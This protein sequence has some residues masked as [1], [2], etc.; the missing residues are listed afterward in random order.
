MFS[1]LVRFVRVNR[2]G[3]ARLAIIRC[4]YTPSV[5]KRTHPRTIT[6]KTRRDDFQRCVRY[7]E[8]LISRFTFYV[9]A[10][11]VFEKFPIDFKLIVRHL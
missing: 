6:N 1:E 2:L 7:N 4:V 8:N 9:I 10:L 11:D 5:S 3:K